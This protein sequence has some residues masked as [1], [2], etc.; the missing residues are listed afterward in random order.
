M[1]A[2]VADKAKLQFSPGL[3][4]YSIALSSVFLACF[5]LSC[6]EAQE[7]E[8]GKE[9]G[10]QAIT[11]KELDDL[12]M[13]KKGDGALLV[14]DLGQVRELKL[15]LGWTEKYSTQPAGTGLFKQW[16]PANE[17]FGICH[18]YRGRRVSPQ[19]GENFKALLAKPEHKL[20]S[21]EFLKL[22]E[23]L[24]EKDKAERFALKDAST[25][26]VNGKVVLV[27]QG[28][29]KE[30]DEDIYEFFVDTDG[31]G[32]AVQELYFQAPPALF[33]KNIELARKA[34]DSI[35]WK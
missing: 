10:K 17:K 8:K 4:L 14:E 13:P 2:R 29:F 19:A 9:K 28:H 26:S 22:S 25:R 31:S 16:G 15:P 33:K 11:D 20:D 7:N 5:C 35:K 6:A 27:V 23:I 18:F 24:R 34:L 1:K 30:I 12:L 3:F 21:A 32:T